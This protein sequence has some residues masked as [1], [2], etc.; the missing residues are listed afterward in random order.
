MIARAAEAFTTDTGIKVDINFNG[1]DIRKT[2]QPALDAGEVI[3]L[4]DE[5]I[6]RVTSAWGNYLL[7]LDTYVSQSYPTTGGQPFGSV[8]NKTLL[9]LARQLGNGT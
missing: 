4:F 5:D 3:D 9:D 8:V 7:P 2:L 1:R 6:D